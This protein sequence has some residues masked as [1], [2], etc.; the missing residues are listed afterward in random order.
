MMKKSIFT[1][2][3]MALVAFASAQSLQF[4]LDGYVYADGERVVCTQAEDWGEMIQEM[5][6]RN[7]SGA[8]LDVMISRE[9]VQLVPGTSNSFCWESCYGPNT[10]ISPRPQTIEAGAVSLPGL[11]SFHQAIASEED[12]SVFITGTSIVKYFAYPA[13]NENDKVCIEVWFAYGA[14]GINENEVVLGHA[15][16]NPASSVVRFD[17]A[18]PGVANASVSVYNLLGQEV[19]K[20]DLNALQGQAVLSV[21]DL[22][23]GIYFCNLKVDGRTVKTEKFIVR[24]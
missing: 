23:E 19:L 22:T 1:L 8:S 3:F 4:E 21:A 18:L 14:E 13:D 24:K 15:Y 20:Q 7:I 6:I 2:A 11:L 12:P 9:I 5:Q 17:Y 10:D 16:P